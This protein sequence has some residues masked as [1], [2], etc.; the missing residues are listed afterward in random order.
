M[1]ADSGSGRQDSSGAWGGGGA[2]HSRAP[3]AGRYRSWPNR[4]LRGSVQPAVLPWVEYAMCVVHLGGYLGSGRLRAAHAWAAAALRVVAAG[5]RRS[6]RAG[7]GW[8]APRVEITSAKGV[9][10]LEGAY[11]GSRT[12]KLQREVTGVDGERRRVVRCPWAGPKEGVPGFWTSLIDAWCS[13][14]GGGGVSVAGA[15]PAASNC[16]DQNYLRRRNPGKIRH[17]QRSRLGL[18]AAV[19]LLVLGRSSCKVGRGCGTAERRVRG[20]AG[21]ELRRASG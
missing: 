3:A 4:P 20:G 18:V 6:C 12:V 16:S 7:A 9:W 17:R 19:L 11:R 13:C 10:G 1:A 5:E 8:C 15:A 14:G 2:R 21:A